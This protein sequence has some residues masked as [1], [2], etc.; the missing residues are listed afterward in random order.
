MIVFKGTKIAVDW[1]LASINERLFDK[2]VV[3]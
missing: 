3:A 2:P 1:Q